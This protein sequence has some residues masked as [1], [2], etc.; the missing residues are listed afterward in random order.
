MIVKD[1]MNAKQKIVQWAFI[2]STGTAAY[3]ALVA[4]F[5]S[6]GEELFGKIDDRFYGPMAFLML[7]VLSATV[8]G[9]LVLG[10]PVVLYFRGL[11]KE[12]ISL[13]LYTTGFMSILTLVV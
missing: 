13:F 6:K 12:A 11:Q 5:M 9:S 4:W 2:N 7:F 10:R 1:D 3:I 8:T